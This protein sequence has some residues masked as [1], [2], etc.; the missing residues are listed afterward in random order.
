MLEIES[1]LDYKFM[2][3]LI[4][5]KPIIDIVELEFLARKLH[6]DRQKQQKIGILQSA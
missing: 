5:V 4:E 3:N 2:I 1:I 6:T